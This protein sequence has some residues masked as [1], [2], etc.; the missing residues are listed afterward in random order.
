MPGHLLPPP[1][2]RV[3]GLSR[4]AKGLL[5]AETPNRKQRKE[6]KKRKKKKKIRKRKKKL[7]NKKKPE[8]KDGR[9]PP[10]NSGLG[11]CGTL[12]I[13]AERRVTIPN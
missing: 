2:S 10:L 9:L 12:G 8:F 6:E 3:Q 11:L 5:S 4:E 13:R 7:I 1:Y